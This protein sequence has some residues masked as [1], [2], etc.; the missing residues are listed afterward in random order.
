MRYTKNFY[1]DI[2]I[3]KRQLVL[4]K[5]KR[6]E[7]Q[8][9]QVKCFRML[10]RGF[11]V[12]H[13]EGTDSYKFRVNNGDRIV[14]KYGESF[15]ELVYMTYSTHD[16]QIRKAKALDKRL[17]RLEIIESQEYDIDQSEYEEGKI[18]KELNHYIKSLYYN[19]YQQIKE[20]ML[21]EE[22]YIPMAV[23]SE[24][25]QD[26]Q[27]LTSQQFDCIYNPA[28][29]T[30]V[31]GC[32]GSG[33][34]LIGLA[35]LKIE[36][37][38]GANTIYVTNTEIMKNNAQRLCI[39]LEDKDKKNFFY[40]IQ[41]LCWK[42]LKVSG[43]SLI[44]Y[45][46][47]KI[48]L[49]DKLGNLLN[50]IS[51]R[52]IWNEISGNIKGSEIK[53][54]SIISKECY[55]QETHSKLGKELKKK[56]YVIATTY[57]NWLKKNGY[58]DENDLL[59]AATT[60]L[61]TPLFEGIIYDEIQELNICAVHFISKL[62]K[63]GHK[64][65]LLGDQYQRLKLSYDNSEIL[66]EEIAINLSLKTL[67]KNY[68]NKLGVIEWNNNL[69]LLQKG[70]EL[71]EAVEL[72]SEPYYILERE[73]LVSKIFQNASNEVESIIVVGCEE[74]RK[75]LYEKGLNI[76]RIFTVEE[77]RGLEYKRVYCYNLIKYIQGTEKYNALYV[78]SSRAKETLYFIETEDTELIKKFTGYYSRITYDELFESFGI[79]LDLGRW[80]EEGKKLER[81]EK[82]VQAMVAYK[83]AGDER[84]VQ[85]CQKAYEKQFA[86]IMLK[87]QGCIL[88]IYADNLTEESLNII[89]ENIW[90]Q[91]NGIKL[92]WV[93]VVLYHEMSGLPMI[94]HVYINNKYQISKAF[95][96]TIV[97]MHQIHI[98]D[99][100]L[101]IKCVLEQQT[102]D[103][104]IHVYQGNVE[105][106]QKKCYMWRKEEEYRRQ[107]EIFAIKQFGCPNRTAIEEIRD[108]EKVK[109]QSTE[110]ILK[111]IFG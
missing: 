30:I 90:S 31:L 104:L 43:K 99:N 102:E 15:N 5:I 108:L 35:K 92:F 75:A 111:N 27:Y 21:V 47:F 61:D 39:W 73:E 83:K 14:F 80:L 86:D 63:G 26:K 20:E 70:E 8:I 62:V 66:K 74:E 55:L 56:I 28:Q 65:L 11:W 67:N 57:Q 95:R 84:A 18:D 16:H 3:E 25:L 10:P 101:T 23:E 72:G 37:I 94:K 48:W 71:E 91:G 54:K 33:K 9:L 64:V 89:F 34:T 7:K 13:I 105:M 24:N 38:V 98:S 76:G 88:D 107:V 46:Q 60:K 32:A 49:E 41:E 100:R 93:Q 19:T 44:G 58:W 45:E 81:Q 36:H 109:S 97:Y 12:R 68:R 42:V 51:A 87:E 4:E 85:L 96:E 78:A 106:Q 69:K 1:N 22:G 52:E 110:D 29:P 77:S 79:E 82:Y 40:S 50:G 103:Y 2:P 6:F 59:R 17:Q 53:E